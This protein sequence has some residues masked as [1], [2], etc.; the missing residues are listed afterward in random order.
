MSESMS[1]EKI[2]VLGVGTGGCRIAAE[3]AATTSAN[4]LKAILIDTDEKALSHFP[5]QQ[6]LLVGSDWTDKQGCGGEMAR[7]EKAAGAS[8]S[9]LNKIISNT[10]F[11]IVVCPL[12]GGTGSGVTPVIASMA[13]RLKIQ[14]LF[15]I[16]RPFSFEG[17]L[18]FKNS[19]KSLKALIKTADAVICLENDILFKNL[20]GNIND[21]FKEADKT[22]AQCVGGISEM[23]F[24]H[25]LITIDFSHIKQLLKKRDADCHIG[26]GRAHGEDKS[27]LAITELM[28]SPTLG[29]DETLSACNTAIVTLLAGPDLSMN[30]INL[31]ISQVKNLFP[32][33]CEVN[34]GVATS[35]DREDFLQV[36]V[37]TIKDRLS[38][39]SHEKKKKAPPQKRTFKKEETVYN[40]QG[41][42][43]LQELTSG[44]FENSAPTMHLGQNLD[45][46]TFLRQGLNLD[47]G[48]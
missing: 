7:G 21:D 30:D 2:T 27:Q 43:A 13:R 36:T 41:E 25:G 26:I 15:F 33:S 44:I 24:S 37:L 17:N 14:S 8:S 12:G 10:E 39:D 46:P 34:I 48:E 42:L 47:I 20:S 4:S 45:I 38:E 19:E 22:L 40:I 16:T 32:E 1:K 31:C 23:L 29:G 35:S 28:N 5:T 3:L 9:A 18:R 11:L 6:T